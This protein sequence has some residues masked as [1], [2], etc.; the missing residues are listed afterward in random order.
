MLFNQSMLE[1]SQ[2]TRYLING[3]VA[4]AIHFLVLTINIK[5]LGWSSAGLS[6]LVASIFGI[7]SSFIGSRYFVFQHSS[8]VL[9]VQIYRFILLYL[10]IALLHGALL[11]IWVDV[12]S[13]NYILGF[14]VATAMQVLFSYVGNK[15]MVFKV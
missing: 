13:L 5:L 7:F 2:P 10:A 15:F 8:E 4:T 3:L 12:Y 9:W 11:Y 6:N 1:F 14:G